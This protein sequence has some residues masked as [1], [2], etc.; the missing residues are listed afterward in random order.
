MVSLNT[1]WSGAG[2]GRVAWSWKER[3]RGKK[4]IFPRYQQYFIISPISLLILIPSSFFF[5]NAVTCTSFWISV[6][7]NI[8]PTPSWLPT[9]PHYQCCP[10]IIKY[11]P[12]TTC[13]VSLQ[14][15]KH[16]S[17]NLQRLTSTLSF[18]LRTWNC[19]W[20]DIALCSSLP[21]DVHATQGL[22]STPLLIDSILLYTTLGDCVYS[23]SFT[24]WKIHGW[25]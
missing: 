8:Q 1:Q 11:R 12:W 25:I 24:P 20:D 16:I 21:L 14:P 3:R 18:L 13:L 7:F 19:V 2:V 22:Q 17:P 9:R 10:R 15:F 23:K 4:K 6:T 5:Y